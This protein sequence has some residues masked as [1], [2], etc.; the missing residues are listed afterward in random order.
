MTGFV[1]WAVAIGRHSPTYRQQNSRDS[2]ERSHTERA[3]AGAFIDVMMVGTVGFGCIT[4]FQISARAS[5]A[6]SLLMAIGWL[7]FS[8]RYKI[9]EHRES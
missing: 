1:T 4:L 7:D 9:L 3:R 2:I 5:M 8:I 6:L